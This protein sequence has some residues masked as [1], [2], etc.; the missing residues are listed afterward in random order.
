MAQCTAKSKR[1]QQRCTRPACKGMN[2]CFQHGGGTPKGIASPHFKHGKRSKYMPENLAAKYQEAIADP[3]LGSL[4]RNIALN[5]AFIREK[6]EALNEGGD[7]AEAWE[8][9]AKALKDL[10]THLNNE[11]YGK[12]LITVEIM[13]DIVSDRQ[14]YHMAVTEIQETLAEQRKDLKVKADIELKEQNAV[15]VTSLMNFIGAIVTLINQ[16]VPENDRRAAISEGIR[17]LVGTNASRQ[18]PS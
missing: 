1:T 5:E 9:I 13:K 3:D 4:L 18:L 8:I 14:R 12:V 7:S 6:L 2:V 17:K 15:S 10:S 11:D 16:V